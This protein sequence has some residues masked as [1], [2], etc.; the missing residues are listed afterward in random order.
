MERKIYHDI[1]GYAIVSLSGK[2]VKVHILEWERINGQK[3][4]GMQLHH[5]DFDKGNY[6]IDNLELVTQ[7]DHFK[8][9]AGWV[10]DEKNQWTHKPCKTCKKL[11]PLLSFYP[12][13]GL[14][15]SNHCI[16]C[17][18]SNSKIKLKNDPVYREKKRL[19]LKD[20]YNRNSK[21]ILQKQKDARNKR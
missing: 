11:L 3:P 5:I 19:Y 6:S 10:R 9:H 14:T 1:K 15:P 4:A 20:Y 21:T 18:G 8:I 13:K 2:C 16:I 7:S 17:T 12:R